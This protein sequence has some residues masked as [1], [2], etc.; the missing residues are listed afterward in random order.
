M[1]QGLLSRHPVWPWLCHLASSESC[2]CSFIL[3]GHVGLKPGSQVL[4]LASPGSR[5]LRTGVCH[6]SIREGKAQARLISQGESRLEKTQTHPVD[7]QWDDWD[8]ET[9]SWERTLSETLLITELSIQTHFYQGTFGERR[10]VDGSIWTKIEHIYYAICKE[11]ARKGK[12]IK[13]KSSSLLMRGLYNGR[14]V[15]GREDSGVWACQ[16]SCISAACSVKWTFK[17]EQITFH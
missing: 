13:K 1:D 9:W 3:K 7:K 10:I 8:R 6:D 15:L 17:T 5:H 4:Q 16:H 11:E 12:K 14:T 2:I